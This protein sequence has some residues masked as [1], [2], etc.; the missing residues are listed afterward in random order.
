MNLKPETPTP[1][2]ALLIFN[3]I[4]FSIAGY[5]F[6][7]GLPV[8]LMALI[9][10]AIGLLLTTALYY[11][12][13][14][15][16]WAA[17]Q[18]PLRAAAAVMGALLSLVLL[19]AFAFRW[20]DEL[21]YPVMLLGVFFSVVIY[22]ALL[23]LSQQRTAIWAWAGIVLALILLVAGLQWLGNEGADPFADDLPPPFE[24][25]SLPTLADQGLDNPAARGDFAVQEFTYGSGTDEQ[26]EVFREDIRFRTPTVDASLLLPDWKGKKKKW[27]EKYWGFGVSDF[28]LNG[29][30]HLPEGNGPFPLVLMVHGNHSMIDY[31]DGGYAYLGDLLASRGFIAVSVDENF[32]NGHWSGDFRG[33]EM[34]TRAWLLLKHLEQWAQWNGA[35]GHELAGKV[36]LENILLIGHSRGGEAVSIAAAF[37]RLSHFPDDARE[38]F[39]FNFNIKGVVALAPTDYRYHRQISL[40]NINFLSLQGAYDADETSFWGMRAYRRLQ[41]TDNQP[42]FKAGVYLHRANHGQFNSSWGRSDFGGPFSWLLNRGALVPGEAQR[43]A[44]KV[45]ISA[46]AEAALKGNREYLPLFRNVAVGR[47]WLPENYYLTH[48]ADTAS[49]TLVDFEDDLDLRTAGREATIHT[50]NLKIWQEEEL[51]TRDG[52]SQEN[53]VAIVGWDYGE[54]V[55]ADSLAMFEIVFSDTTLSLIDSVG[56][57]RLVLAAG[58]HQELD[59]LTKPAKKRDEPVLDLRIVLIDRQ[60]RSASTLLSA[61]KA[62]APRLKSRFTKL[63]GLDK[64]LVGEEWEVQPETFFLPMEAFQPEGAPPNLSELQRIRLVFDQS[65][66]GLIVIDDIGFQP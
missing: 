1:F 66:Y 15:L 33:K 57:L 6:A 38:L 14:L 24:K 41:F 44:A 62:L 25:S 46:F 30:V 13:R 29:R 55:P 47:D 35:A 45:F 3:A 32:I 9:G 26:R 34:P 59:Q 28:P 43:E 31:S 27:R 63:A 53:N 54:Q 16:G 21:F 10:G 61:T 65:A 42:W 19:K 7:T 8:W 4:V 49:R 64:D 48:F 40:E 2:P 60:G 12:F 36:D 51:K 52:G 22:Y 17:D 58:K 18:V 23:R 50:E 39:D 5:Y 56:S 11:L 37:N 20:P